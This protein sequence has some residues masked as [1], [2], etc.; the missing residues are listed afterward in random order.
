[1]NKNIVE[2][3][4]I[5]EEKP[6]IIKNVDEINPIKINT[7]RK[8]NRLG[9]KNKP[10]VKIE[11]NRNYQELRKRLNKQLGNH[12][13]R[14]E[15]EKKSKHA[16]HDNDDIVFKGLTDIENLFSGIDENEYCKPILV[17]TFNKDGYKEYESKGDITKSL[18]LEEYIQKIT[19][20]LKELIDI[21]KNDSNNFKKWKIQINARIKNVSIENSSDVRTSY[22]WSKNKEIR[23]EY[24]TNDIIDNTLES[25]FNNYQKEEEISREKSKIY[26]NTNFIKQV[27]KEEVHI[28]SHQNG[29]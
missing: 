6:V 24:D 25:F 16:K 21:H 27:Q 28:L 5:I 3:T 22:V 23:S 4:K 15:N 2:I 7:T 11:R 10:K 13:K 29:Y 20:Y 14:L 26:Y 8:G 18:S 17:K 1:M 19:P 12:L 9:K